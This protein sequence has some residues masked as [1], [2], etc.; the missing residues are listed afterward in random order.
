MD[1][2]GMST[3]GGFEGPPSLNYTIQRLHEEIDLIESV[4]SPVSEDTT[5]LSP[6]IRS[7]R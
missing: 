7:L 2:R 1:L 6:A 5:V 4:E 3:Y